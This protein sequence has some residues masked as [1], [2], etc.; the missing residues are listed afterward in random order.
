MALDIEIPAALGYARTH[1]LH[2]IVIALGD[3]IVAQEYGDGFDAKKPHLLYSGTKSFWGPAALCA[4]EDGLL[5]LD[6]AV[7]ATFAEWRDDP[8]KRRVTLRMLLSLTAGFGFGGLGGAVPEYERALATPLKNEPG[9]RFTYGGVPFQVFGAVLARKLAD[10]KLTPHDYL[11]RRILDPAAVRVA[12]WRSL[13]DGTHP[14]PTG[15]SLRA[16]DWL[17]YGRYVTREA[18]RL[19]PCF[20]GSPANARYG[21][22]WWL[23]AR[24]SPKD[25]VYASGSA[26]QA[27]YL[28]PSLDL[29]VV[30]FGASASFRHETFLRRLFPSTASGDTGAS[31]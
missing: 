29:T 30:H 12:S 21:L 11:R 5:E 28:V 23:G 20:E 27:L 10:R 16:M 8:W 13:K 17:A 24:N 18:D 14:L 6:E 31:G 15:A 19:G 7:A 3:Q 2:A 26:G 25:L 4:R 9:S 22:G 1:A